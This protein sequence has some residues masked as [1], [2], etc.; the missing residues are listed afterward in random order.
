MPA[1]G[2]LPQTTVQLMCMGCTA[3]LSATHLDPEAAVS[4][5]S[6]EGKRL[7]WVELPPVEGRRPWP[8]DMCSAC[9]A[10]LR[11]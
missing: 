8:V 10:E 1:P 7:A 4:A 3:R 11:A 5:V 2:G 9:V 6:A